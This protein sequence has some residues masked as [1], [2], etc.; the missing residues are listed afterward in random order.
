MGRAKN[1]SQK[2]IDNVIVDK[3]KKDN[4][5]VIVENKD[6][7]KMVLK[8]ISE[9]KLGIVQDFMFGGPCGHFGSCLEFINPAI[10]QVERFTYIWMN[11]LSEETRKAIINYWLTSENDARPREYSCYLNSPVWKY[12]SSVIKLAKEYTCEK[13]G[14]KYNPAFLSVHHMSYAHLGS[15]L[16][17]LDE[18]A[19]LCRTC[20]MKVHGIRGADECK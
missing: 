7:R 14:K 8:D 4:D 16:E 9:Y 6:I 11:E 20:H 3:R 19:V 10:K 13:C 1:K 15:E 17:H 2:D 18:L 5:N 12:V